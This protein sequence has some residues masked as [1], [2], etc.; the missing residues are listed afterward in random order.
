MSACYVGVAALLVLIMSDYGI[1]SV[2]VQKAVEQIRSLGTNKRQRL[3]KYITASRVGVH[4]RATSSEETMM[5][6]KYFVLPSQLV[7]DVT[8][9]T[10][11]SCSL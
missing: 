9:Q 4:V 6:Y 7:A 2:R 1:G 11:S 5:I 8:N 3:S 10:L